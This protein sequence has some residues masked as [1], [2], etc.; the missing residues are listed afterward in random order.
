MK[1]LKFLAEERNIAAAE[2]E[3]TDTFA[4]A[5]AHGLKCKYCI[6]EQERYQRQ[7]LRDLCKVPPVSA[8]IFCGFPKAVDAAGFP[9]K[10]LAICPQK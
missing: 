1:A 8:I 5:A 3:T 4:D 10:C 2:H 7:L 6:L 9:A